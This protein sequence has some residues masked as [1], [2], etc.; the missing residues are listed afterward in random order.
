[1]PGRCGNI[2]GRSGGFR[3]R[4]FSAELFSL[5]CLRGL[6][7]MSLCD[8]NISRP[9]FSETAQAN[10]WHCANV[11][12]RPAGRRGSGGFSIGHELGLSAGLGSSFAPIFC[13][14]SRGEPCQHCPFLPD[15]S[16]LLN[17]FCREAFGSG[18]PQLKMSFWKDFGDVPFRIVWVKFI[19]GIVSIGGGASLGRE[20]P[21]VQLAGTL[22]SN[23]AAMTERSNKIAGPPR[24]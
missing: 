3:L 22:G 20:D 16:W 17:S 11:P 24:P 21:S 2:F 1:M 5:Y 9:H 19:A 10:A 18:I 12:L 6:F 7:N 4:P 15:R 23:L 14:L 13:H 8:V